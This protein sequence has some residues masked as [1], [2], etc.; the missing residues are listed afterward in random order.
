MQKEK[1]ACFNVKHLKKMSQ[2]YIQELC[3][4]FNKRTLKFQRNPA[5]IYSNPYVP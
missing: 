3:H 5:Y 2:M 1:F 4:S